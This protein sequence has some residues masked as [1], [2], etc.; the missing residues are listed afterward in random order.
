MQL[1]GRC[2]CALMGEPCTVGGGSEPLTGLHPRCPG[3]QGAATA[4][5]EPRPPFPVCGPFK[6]GAGPPWGA[7][8]RG[9]VTAALYKGGGIP[10]AA[11]A[12]RAGGATCAGPGQAQPGGGSAPAMESAGLFPPFPAASIPAAAAS[13]TPPAPAP[14]PR[15]A[16]TTRIITDPISGRSY[17]KGRLLGKVPAVRERGWAVARGAGCAG[18][19]D[20]RE[21][22]TCSIPPHPGRPGDGCSPSAALG[23]PHP[24]RLCRRGWKR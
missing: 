13:R 7:E 8:L 24:P 11:A 16:E 20:G 22:R 18:A 17:C 1:L 19:G 14:P 6:G 12:A 10:G 21:P 2:H 5:P 4:F 15:A 23:R 3:C 9:D